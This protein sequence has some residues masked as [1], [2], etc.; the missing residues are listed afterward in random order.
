MHLAG[1]E[2]AQSVAIGMGKEASRLQPASANSIAQK[3]HLVTLAILG[4]VG[5]RLCCAWVQ[6]ARL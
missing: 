4:A 2:E 6:A 3:A 5:S 1:L